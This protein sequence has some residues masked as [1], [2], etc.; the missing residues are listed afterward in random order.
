MRIN[1]PD[2]CYPAKK[3]IQINPLS[4]ANH[5]SMAKLL[6]ENCPCFRYEFDKALYVGRNPTSLSEIITVT[7]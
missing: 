2:R 6:K 3:L 5:D 1:A 7:E 4:R